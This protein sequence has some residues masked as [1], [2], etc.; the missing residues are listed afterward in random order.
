M[1]PAINPANK[2]HLPWRNRKGAKRFITSNRKDSNGDCSGISDG[3]GVQKILAL[4][5]LC[6]GQKKQPDVGEKKSEKPKK[7]VRDFLYVRP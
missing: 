3:Y 7:C 1:E 2:T 5:G 6:F 4:V